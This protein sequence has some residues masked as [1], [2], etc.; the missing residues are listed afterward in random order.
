[1]K[2]ARRNTGARRPGSTA[3]PQKR[4]GG[5]RPDGAGKGATRQAARPRVHLNRAMSKLGLLTRSQA[6]EAILAGRVL[7]D[8]RVVRDPGAPIDPTRAAITVN[9]SEAIPAEWRTLVFHKPR[10]VV[11]TRDDPQG[12][13][14]IYDV[15]GEPAQG[16]V[17]VGRLDLATSG[18]LLLTTDRELASW[19]TDPAN[20]VSRLY[21]ASVRGRVTE[22][23]VQQLLE[24]ILDGGDMLRAEHVEVRKAS[25][26]ES[27][28]TIELRE[29]KNR[30]VRRLLDAVGHEVTRLKRVRVGTLDLG[31]MAPGTWRELERDEV[32]RAFPGSEKRRAPVAA[33]RRRREPSRR[34]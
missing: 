11:T 10:G 1:M 2:Q 23:D 20:Q 16:L 6:T 3:A 31:E 21:I 25:N 32:L 9:G 29:G 12:R 30:A 5:P 8:G 13:Q 17:P 14:T 19:M 26:R 24:G 4:V 27:H 22:A 15:I 33:V 34:R 18:L 7:V 28:L